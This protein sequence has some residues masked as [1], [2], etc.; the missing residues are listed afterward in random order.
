MSRGPGRTQQAILNAL[1]PRE[2]TSTSALADTIGADPRQIRAAV[3]SLET[4]KLLV[5]RRNYCIGW[6]EKV[7]LTRNKWKNVDGFDEPNESAVDLIVDLPIKGT[8]VWSLTGWEAECDDT[9][10][11]SR[12]LGG[13]LRAD[14]RNPEDPALT[15]DT[16]P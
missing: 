3:R 7:K 4:R 8:L 15:P 9:E 1:D 6:R 16:T 10:R 14:H 2:P 12:I 13:R 11:L 5:C